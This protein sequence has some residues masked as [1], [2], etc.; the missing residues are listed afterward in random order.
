MLA[1]PGRDLHQAALERLLTLGNVIPGLHAFVPRGELRLLRNPSHRLGP[2]ER[3]FPIGVPAVVELAGVLVRPLLRHMVGAVQ[4]AA[5]PVHEE[6]LVG[7]ERLV[8]VQPPDRVVREVLAEVVPLLRGLRRQHTGGVPDQVRLVLRRLAGQEAVEV[9]EAQP[10]R[11]V[12]ERPCR[13][14]F[15]GR[16]V[17]PLAPRGRSSSRSASARR[18]PER[19][20]WGSL[21][22]TRP[23][24]SRAP[25]SGRCRSGGGCGQSATTPASGSTSLWCETGCS[26]CPRHGSGSAC[27]FAPLRRT[28]SA[29]RAR[30]RRSGRSGCSAHHPA[31]DGAPRDARTST[32]ASS[33]RPC[34]PR[35]SEGT[36]TP[37]GKAC[38]TISTSKSVRARRR[39][40]PT[41]PHDASGRGFTRDRSRASSMAGEP[42]TPA[43]PQRIPPEACPPEGPATADGLGVS[44]RVA[45]R[46]GAR[47]GW[48]RYRGSE[49]GVLLGGTA[50]SSSVRT[51]V[52][53]P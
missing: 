40:L 27:R 17:V 52:I 2:V 15:Q 22:S 6:R 13:G 41:T 8:P 26:R 7:L 20:S 50:G 48:S 45:T 32:P 51:G 24:R 3:P 5:G 11:P 29:V 12:V 37:L 31:A 30:R 47:D 38:D 28:S 42:A 53:P 33:A 1:E 39:R 4:T 44:S 25:R 43:P 35:G 9:L 46:S 49:P 21:R 10:C 34:W 36:A 19:C 16:G 18:R 14:G 23:S